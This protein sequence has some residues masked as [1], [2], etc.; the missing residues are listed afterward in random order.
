MACASSGQQQGMDI[1]TSAIAAN[2]W[3]VYEKVGRVAFQQ[4]NLSFI[5]LDCEVQHLDRA[6][7]NKHNFSRGHIKITERNHTA[8]ISRLTYKPCF[9]SHVTLIMLLTFSF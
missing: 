5:S 7:P 1:T 9:I 2:I 6:I 8:Y 4:Q 3:R